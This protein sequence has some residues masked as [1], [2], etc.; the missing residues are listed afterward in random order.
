LQTFRSY[1]HLS[2]WRWQMRKEIV[3]HRTTAGK[4]QG[5]AEW[6]DLDS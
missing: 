1:A 6:L 4:G 5:K 2:S 3:E